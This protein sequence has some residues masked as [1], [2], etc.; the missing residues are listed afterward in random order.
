MAS[1]DTA[2]AGRD[3]G[4]AAGGAGSALILISTDAHTFQHPNV[5]FRVAKIVSHHL[6]L[7]V[8][9]SGVSNNGGVVV[10]GVV[11]EAALVRTQVRVALHVQTV[12]VLVRKALPAV[13]IV[14][15]EL[16]VTLAEVLHC[17]APHRAS[18]VAA[19]KGA[20]DDALQVVLVRVV[21]Q[22]A[23]VL[24]DLQTEG[25]LEGTLIAVHL[26][27]MFIQLMSK[28]KEKN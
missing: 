24:E 22:T 18:P 4:G 3:G 10:G 11:T 8:D 28:R 15:G 14:A 25:T 16:D 21:R 13:G 9:I 23:V 6:P 20:G 5:V 7:E 12:H 1:S 2:A 26:T 19:G 17:F 27:E